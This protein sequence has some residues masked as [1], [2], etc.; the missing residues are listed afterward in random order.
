MSRYLKDDSDTCRPNWLLYVVFVYLATVFLYN[1]FYYIGFDIRYSL[2]LLVAVFAIYTVQTRLIWVE[3]NSVSYLIMA[4]A[5]LMSFLG[6]NS[7]RDSTMVKYISMMLVMMFYSMTSIPNKAIL[8]R[9]KLLIWI[10]ADVFAVI[11]IISRFEPNLYF[12]TI[13]RIVAS[14]VR[15]KSEESM[16]RGYSC[17]IGG[18]HTYCNYVFMLAGF[19][20]FSDIIKGKSRFIV[21]FLHIAF[22]IV[23]SFLTGRRGEVI[24]F[25]GSLLVVISIIRPSKEIMKRFICFAIVMV[26]AIVLFWKVIEDS[27]IFT[28]MRVTLSR[29]EDGLDI[30]TGRLDIWETAIAIFKEHPIV[31]IGWGGFAYYVPEGH[32]NVSNVHNIYLQFLAETGV[33]GTTLIM[34]GMINLLINT[35]ILIN[36]LRSQLRYK[37]ILSIMAISLGCQVYFIVLGFVDPCFTKTYYWCFV[38]IEIMLNRYANYMYIE[39]TPKQISGIALSGSFGRLLREE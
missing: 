6:Q 32:E 8:E 19:F 3:S 30:T 20:A 21:S 9:C 13:G 26:I 33:V 23:A 16:L 15:I 39:A 5:I 28:R 22:Y 12:S 27:A 4:T 24:A 29:A 37:Y 34:L 2:M 10:V 18:S 14:D 38:L 1:D 31:G 25:V 35:I 17:A 36:D 11:V 7:R